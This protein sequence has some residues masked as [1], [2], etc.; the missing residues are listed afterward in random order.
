MQERE[1]P[2]SHHKSNSF[3]C[4][5]EELFQVKT[6]AKMEVTGKSVHVIYSNNGVITCKLFN[7]FL[8]FSF[9]SCTLPGKAFRKTF[10]E[11][12]VSGPPRF[13]RKSS[14]RNSKS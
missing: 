8:T 4:K 13:N 7:S 10:N 5:E 1:L 3:L 11:K 9:T 2:V 6:D 12:Y 14:L